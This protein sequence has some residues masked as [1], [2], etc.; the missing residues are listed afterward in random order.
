MFVLLSLN[1]QQPS[2]TQLLLLTRVRNMACAL[3][4]PRAARPTSLRSDPQ[5]LEYCTRN[6][7]T[8]FG[9]WTVLLWWQ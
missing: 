6:L 7:S 3:Y 5:D 4:L 8:G 1:K 9:E 2:N